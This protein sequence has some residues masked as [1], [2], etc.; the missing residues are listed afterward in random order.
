[1]TGFSQVFK[2]GVYLS[3]PKVL[4]ILMED[5]EDDNR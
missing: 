3:Y 2:M 4:A 5:V 1:V